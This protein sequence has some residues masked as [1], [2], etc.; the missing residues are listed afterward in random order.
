[1]SMFYFMY[2]LQII[3]L[4]FAHHQ[5]LDLVF[6]A[7]KKKPKHFKIQTEWVEA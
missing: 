7:G 1:M 3:N 6:K 5:T 4:S 2:K